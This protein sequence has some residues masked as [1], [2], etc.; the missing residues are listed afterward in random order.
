MYGDLAD[1]NYTF[2]VAA[3]DRAG[4]E[5]EPESYE[6]LLD[7]TPPTISSIAYP[8]GSRTG[9]FTVSFLV[10]DDSGSGVDTVSCRYDSKMITQLCEPPRVRRGHVCDTWLCVWLCATE[11]LVLS[12]RFAQYLYWVVNMRSFQGTTSP[13]VRRG[14]QPDFRPV[15]MARLHQPC[16]LQ[17]PSSWALG[18]DP[19]SHRQGGGAASH[20]V[21]SLSPDQK[22]PLTLAAAS[23]SMSGCDGL[24]CSDD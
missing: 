23:K 20:Q 24:Q 15:P 8:R 9:N 18:V 19:R 2:S 11:Y 7:T 16:H 4:N 22:V 12:A 21:S 3:R 13:S 1:G 10:S 17:R 5:A 6:F 14:C